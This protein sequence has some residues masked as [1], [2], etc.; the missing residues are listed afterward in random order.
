MEEGAMELSM[1]CFTLLII[2]LVHR[3]GFGI[4]EMRG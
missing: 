3:D 1:M 4:Y 2:P